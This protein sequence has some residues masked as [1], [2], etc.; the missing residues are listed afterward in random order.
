MLLLIT[1]ASGVGKTSARAAI[2]AGLA[3]GVEC[4][5]LHDLSPPSSPAA[6]TR[7]WRQHAAELAVRRAIELQATG[8]HL[9][10]AG[11]PVPAVEVVAAP[12]SPELVAL[13]VCL[14][15][16]DAPSQASR[17]TAR[18]DAAELLPH[19]QAFADWMRHQATDPLHMPHVVADGGWDEMRWERLPRVTDRW[20]MHVI[21][22]SRMTPPDIAAH[23][24][25][26]CRDATGGSAPVFRVPG[27]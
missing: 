25:T 20:D 3:P 15:D 22:T 27:P 11:D 9:L 16:A 24:L 8:R 12:S 18:G 5:E 26:W 23:A 4:V 2:A 1:G 7:V 17:L 6:A 21:D 10:L 13:A 14:L 19:H